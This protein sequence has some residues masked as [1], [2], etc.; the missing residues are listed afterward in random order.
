LLALPWEEGLVEELVEGLVEHLSMETPKAWM[1]AKLLQTV[2]R[3]A[4]SLAGMMVVPKVQKT[5]G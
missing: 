5:V 3:W 1:R 4:L 2:L